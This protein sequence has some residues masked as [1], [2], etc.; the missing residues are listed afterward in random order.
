MKEIKYFFAVDNTSNKYTY[1]I[2]ISRDLL[3]QVGIDIL[4]SK[5]YLNRNSIVI[6][7]KLV[8]NIKIRDLNCNTEG[9]DKIEEI[10]S[11]FNNYLDQV[12]EVV[13]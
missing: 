3:N 8:A 11:V 7:I 2:I 12:L 13:L 10:M 4:Y 1:N 9:A 6:P 5:D